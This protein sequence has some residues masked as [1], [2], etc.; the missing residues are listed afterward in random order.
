MNGKIEDRFLS[1]WLVASVALFIIFTVLIAPLGQ[2]KITAWEPDFAIAPL[3]AKNKMY[4]VAAK[5]GIANRREA[6]EMAFAKMPAGEGWI[7]FPLSYLFESSGDLDPKFKKA[8]LELKK[9]GYD[10]ETAYFWVFLKGD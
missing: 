2:N 6:L 5:E 7:H 1:T 10:T 4:I 3:S 8:S 9:K